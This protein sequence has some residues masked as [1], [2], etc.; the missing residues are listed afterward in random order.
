MLRIAKMAILLSAVTACAA[1]R[2]PPIYDYAVKPRAVRP[3]W[4][5]QIDPS[6]PPA[7]NLAPA[8]QEAPDLLDPLA[9][10]NQQVR[11]ARD[12]IR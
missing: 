4:H 11:R 5:R 3:H 12:R 8:P 6:P 9:D 10:L 7:L 1:D 2:P